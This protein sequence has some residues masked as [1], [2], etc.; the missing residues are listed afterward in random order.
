MAFIKHYK[1]ERAMDNSDT[2]Q[3]IQ[4]V[5]LDVELDQI[6]ANSDDVIALLRMEPNIRID[7]IT[8]AKNTANWVRTYDIGVFDS[9]EDAVAGMTATYSE[10]GATSNAVNALG[11][12]IP[13]E[14]SNPTSRKTPYY[15]GIKRKT[16]TSA[17]AA[18]S[19][20]SVYVK[21]FNSDATAVRS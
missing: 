7:S 6:A 2:G 13:Q 3:M 1:A 19:T 15:F 14:P 10:A 20:V 18:A 16:S 8:I 17:E 11:G 5:I 9:D 21:F 12:V 4:E